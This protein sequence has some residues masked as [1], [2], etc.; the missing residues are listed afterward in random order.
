MSSFLIFILCTILAVHEGFPSSIFLQLGDVFSFG[1]VFSLAHFLFHYFFSVY[2][3]RAAD[4]PSVYPAA[5]TSFVP[6]ASAL[7]PPSPEPNLPSLWIGRPCM[8]S[9]PQ[10]T[11]NFA[12]LLSLLPFKKV[13]LLLI[14]FGHWVKHSQN[15][16]KHHHSALH[17]WHFYDG[18]GNRPQT[19]FKRRRSCWY[20]NF[21]YRRRFPWE[22]KPPIMF[23]GSHLN[24]FF[25]EFG[26]RLRKEGKLTNEML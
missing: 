22:T 6:A 15:L 4:L 23:P 17:S 11:W 24:L 14:V 12:F 5:D 16:Y 3:P 2:P 26:N 21:H 20:I 18:C 8:V 1:K 7:P 9:D 19:N 10:L 25:K 13:F